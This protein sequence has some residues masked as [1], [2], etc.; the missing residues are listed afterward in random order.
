MSSRIV[1]DPMNTLEFHLLELTKKKDKTG[2]NPINK[3]QNSAKQNINSQKKV[4]LQ[5]N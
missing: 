4:T 3:Y 5:K 1:S 2:K